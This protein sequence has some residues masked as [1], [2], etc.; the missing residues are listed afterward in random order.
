M[1][2]VGNIVHIVISG[3]VIIGVFDLD[4]DANELANGAPPGT[5]VE[6]WLVSVKA[7]VSPRLVKKDVYAIGDRVVYDDGTDK[8]SGYVN[9]V[10]EGLYRISNETNAAPYVWMM[11][12][13]ILGIYS[14]TA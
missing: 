2:E 9:I 12:Q 7:D 11:T 1:S 3:G 10:R 5:V 6:P 4:S 13:E 14:E 8:G